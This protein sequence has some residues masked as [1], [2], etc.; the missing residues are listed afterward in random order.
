VRE[1]VPD[2]VANTISG[3]LLTLTTYYPFQSL[4]TSCGRV[5][6]EKLT[7]PKLIKKFPAFYRTRRLITAFTSA[8]HLPL[9]EPD[10]SS[11]FHHPIS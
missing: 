4:L 2:T 6:L 7:G 10:Q 9:L 3:L 8:R 1:Y 5:F 11:R